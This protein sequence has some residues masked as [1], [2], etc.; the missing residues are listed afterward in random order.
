MTQAMVKAPNSGWAITQAPSLLGDELQQWTQLLEVRLGMQLPT[1][2]QRFLELNLAR[3][4]QVLG[5][6]NYAQ[7]Y[8]FL[9]SGTAG[10]IEWMQLVDCLTVQETRFFRDPDA[11]ALAQSHMN[12]CYQRGKHNL[13][14]WSLGCSTGEEAYSLAMLAAEVSE[15]YGKLCRFGV[16]ATDISAQAIEQARQARY[17]ISKLGF[18]PQVYLDRF[19][20]PSG[21]AQVSIA[22][23]LRQR[24]CFIRGNLQDVGKNPLRDLDII[25]CQNVL[26]YFSQKSRAALLA[27]LVERL[28]PGGLLILGAGEYTGR[29]PKEMRR[30]D[31]N[32]VSAWQKAS[33][34][35][36]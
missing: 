14:L 32:K 6:A 21:D 13:N 28:A 34:N 1:Y 29:L 10:Q 9:D 31:N 30:V 26:I 35:S 25:F 2:R 36:G 3:R 11:L 4:M 5:L 24:C 15:Q 17:S 18:L 27:P 19:C 22:P 23:E 8:A 12:S 20:Q 33:M 16:F 7:Y